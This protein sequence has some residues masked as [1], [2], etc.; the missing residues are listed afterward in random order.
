MTTSTGDPITMSISGS[1]VA[2]ETSPTR[3]GEPNEPDQ[4]LLP[5]EISKSTNKGG[6]DVPMM[7]REVDSQDSAQDVT[8]SDATHPEYTIQKE[9]TPSSRVGSTIQAKSYLR[10]CLSVIT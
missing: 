6:V 5:Q 7:D 1:A 9:V 4:N 8:I 3:A 10:Y 2:V